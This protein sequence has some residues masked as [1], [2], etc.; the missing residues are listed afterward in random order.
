[1]FNPLDRSL[2][3]SHVKEALAIPA[4]AIVPTEHDEKIVWAMHI[5][6]ACT[7]ENMQACMTLAERLGMM[8]LVF[9]MRVIAT[10]FTKKWDISCD[11]WIAALER[12]EVRAYVARAYEEAAK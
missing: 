8:Y 6:Y 7:D 12:N 9:T 11:V 4:T 1:M 3:A 2:L 10:V 5:G